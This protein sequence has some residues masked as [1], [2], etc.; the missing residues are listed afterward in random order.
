MMRI[1]GRRILEKYDKS[2]LFLSDTDKVFFKTPLSTGTRLTTGK[3]L[4]LFFDRDDEI[5]DVLSDKYFKKKISALF[6]KYLCDI[7]Y[8]K[9]ELDGAVLIDSCHPRCTRCY[10]RSYDIKLG[11]TET[12]DIRFD[13]RSVEYISLEKRDILL[14]KRSDFLY[15]D[16]D[17]FAFLTN[18]MRNYL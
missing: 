17:D 6:E 10:V 8:S 11:N 7:K 5:I 15:I 3:F 9:I 18:N 1:S 2:N 12:L 13:P 16:T 14:S 4:I